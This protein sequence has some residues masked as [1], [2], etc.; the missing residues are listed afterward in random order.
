MLPQPINSSECH[1]LHVMYVVFVY[2][3]GYNAG[4]LLRLYQGQHTQITLS[5]Q[6]LQSQKYTDK[7]VAWKLLTCVYLA[8]WLDSTA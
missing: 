1:A 4:F 5:F 8:I 3:T 6:T 7:D 2:A